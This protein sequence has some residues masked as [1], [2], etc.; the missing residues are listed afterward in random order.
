MIHAKSASGSD[1]A[2]SPDLGFLHLY[3]LAAFRTIPRDSNSKTKMQE[4][5]TKSYMVLYGLWSLSAKL[6]L[7][8]FQV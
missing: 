1:K 6:S 2:R 4:Q 8:S 5:E 3:P 7:L